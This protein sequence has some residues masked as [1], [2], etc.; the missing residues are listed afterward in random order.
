MTVG[1]VQ[2]GRRVRGDADRLVDDHDVVVV[3]H[4]PEA[5]DGLGHQPYGRRRVGQRHLEPAAGVHPGGL[6]DHLPVELH[7]AAG[8][9][10]GGLG[11]R[12]AEQP[13]Q[14]GVDALALEALGHGQ[15]AVLA[16]VRSSRR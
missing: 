6:A 13:G 12:D 9:E 10:V 2:P 3:V 8:G 11:P 14:S 4:D 16:H 5:L 7:V 15:A 1:P